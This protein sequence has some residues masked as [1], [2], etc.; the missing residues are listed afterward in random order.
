MK[1]NQ[2]IAADSTLP[3]IGSALMT[4]SGFESGS[5]FSLDD[6]HQTGFSF[7]TR[8]VITDQMLTQLSA[9]ATNEPLKKSAVTLSRIDMITFQAGGW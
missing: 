3:T 9:N 4:V 1:P 2:A 8:W 5:R 7:R 6:R